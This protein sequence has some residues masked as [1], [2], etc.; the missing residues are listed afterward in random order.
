MRLVLELFVILGVVGVIMLMGASLGMYECLVMILSIGLSVDCAP[1][2]PRARPVGG[3]A[4][5]LSPFSSLPKG[6]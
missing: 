3:A 6:L 2:R 1:A 5:P 4:P